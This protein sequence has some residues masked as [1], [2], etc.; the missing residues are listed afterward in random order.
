MKYSATGYYK[1]LT[2]GKVAK[3]ENIWSNTD[4]DIGYIVWTDY[5]SGI[6]CNL[7]SDGPEGFALPENSTC[8]LQWENTGDWEG[9]LFYG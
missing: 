9:V 2:S 6:Q 3:V 5:D 8:E 1:S 7:L 4:S